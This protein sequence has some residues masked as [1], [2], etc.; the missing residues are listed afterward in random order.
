MSTPTETFA[1]IPSIER[2]LREDNRITGSIREETAQSSTIRENV[3]LGATVQIHATILK[4]GESPG[5][6]KVAEYSATD[7]Y[8]FA[9]TPVSE[10]NRYMSGLV[11]ALKRVVSRANDPVSMELAYVDFWSRAETSKN[12]MGL[13]PQHD[14]LIGVF[15][16]LSRSE[17]PA[18]ASLDKVTALLAALSPFRNR[19]V[20]TDDSLD[21]FEDILESAGFDL[22]SALIPCDDE[23]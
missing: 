19:L 10:F 1:V 23:G 3:S 21:Q 18:I 5:V 13:S 2:I 20:I 16:T 6:V 9:E 15:L 4:P 14:E 7:L 17:G 22:N 8:Y 11:D 12:F